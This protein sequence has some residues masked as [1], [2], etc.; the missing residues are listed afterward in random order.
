MKFLKMLIFVNWENE[1]LITVDKEGEKYSQL[2]KNALKSLISP[3][4]PQINL[5]LDSRDYQICF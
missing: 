1:I 2:T 5:S 3:S 4:K